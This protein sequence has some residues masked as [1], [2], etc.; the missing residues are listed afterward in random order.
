MATQTFNPSANSG[1]LVSN[2]TTYTT[3]RAGGGSVT[4]GP[5]NDARIGQRLISVNY[6]CWELFLEFDLTALSGATITAATLSVYLRF[7]DGSTGHVIKARA[8]DY[9][10]LA[11]SDFVPG[12]D[13]AAL[14]ELATYTVASPDTVYKAFTDTAMV[15]N[16]TEG[17]LNRMVLATTRMEAGTV[18]TANEYTTVYYDN[19]AGFPATLDITYTPPAAPT[20]NN[21]LG[22]LGVGS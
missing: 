8:R 10:T 2:S 3:A 12:A 16:L 9:G 7:R 18:P 6:Y 4:V 19:V 22:T 15:A 1:V 21:S 14:T 11:T 17:A 5:N 20:G 13:L